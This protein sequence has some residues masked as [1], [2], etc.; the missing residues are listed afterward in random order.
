MGPRGSCEN[1]VVH[2]AGLAKYEQRWSNGVGVSALRL[3]G[4]GMGRARIIKP[5]V[6]FLHAFAGWALC[7]AT[8]GIGMSTMAESTALVVHAILAPVFFAALSVLYF[9]TFNYTPPLWTAVM[10]LLFVVLVD[11]FVVA[12]LILGNLEMFAS[13]LGTWVP[14]VLIFLATYITGKIVVS[15]KSRKVASEGST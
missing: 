14:F 11:F 7:A 9:N 8:M 15:R 3:R 4:I 13:P 6:I 5:V 1:R 12:L 2:E 10:F